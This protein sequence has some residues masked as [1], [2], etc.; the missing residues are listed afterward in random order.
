MYHAQKLLTLHEGDLPYHL[1]SLCNGVIETMGRVDYGGRL[2]RNFTAH[3]KVDPES[4]EHLGALPVADQDGRHH[5]D[6]LHALVATETGSQPD[7]TVFPKVATKMLSQS[8]KKVCA[9]LVLGCMGTAVAETGSVSGR[10]QVL[11]H[12]GT[13][14]TGHLQ[15]GEQVGSSVGQCAASL[16][17]LGIASFAQHVNTQE[18]LPATLRAAAAFA[19]YSADHSMLPQ[20]LLCRRLPAWC[21]LE[22]LC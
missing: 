14:C 2:K 17:E 21:T 5:H 22:V 8:G 3:P 20:R 10:H 9:W 11:R 18:G 13:T 7:V 12:M 15:R 19:A 1:R 4:G 16:H 6:P